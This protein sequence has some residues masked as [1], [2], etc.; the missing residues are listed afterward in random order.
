MTTDIPRRL[1]SQTRRW[2]RLTA[3]CD[4]FELRV[5][6]RESGFHDA[7]LLP[8]LGAEERERAARFV[9]DEA[10]HRYTVA[11]AWLR[12]VLGAETGLA[13]D[14]LVF[15]RE[16][17]GKPRLESAAVDDPHGHLDFNL[18]HSG[19]RI[20]LALGR[21]VRLGADVET[22]A[23]FAALDVV[24][25]GV[26]TPRE[27]RLF[28]ALPEQERSRAFYTLWTRKEALLKGVGYGITH[29]PLEEVDVLSAE[30]EK[31]ARFRDRIRIGFEGR[32]WSLITRM[33][34]AEESVA[35][36]AWDCG[37]ADST[38]LS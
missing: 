22:F 4:V 17:F 18:S 37:L 21:G 30:E 20:L 7:D 9:G 35:S 10:R 2:P 16:D 12:A 3:S 25:G 32:K 23:P 38:L 33:E 6:E 5:P 24:A 29:V 36:I 34:D 19:D 28:A 11:H 27:A 1:L 26:L 15:G 14:A 13:P 8:F 31:E